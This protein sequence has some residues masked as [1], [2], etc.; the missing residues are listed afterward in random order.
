[1]TFTEFLQAIGL[2]PRNEKS[3]EKSP[4]KSFKKHLSPEQ[5]LLV[6]EEY[7]KFQGIVEK[8]FETS[9]KWQHDYIKRSNEVCPKCQSKNVNDRIQRL[10][11]EFSG[12]ISG[13]SSLLGGG[14]LSGHSSGKID[15]NEI[16]KCNDCQ[17]EWK[18]QKY[19]YTSVSDKAKS[20]FSDLRWLMNDYK[21]ALKVK[22]DPTDLAEKFDSDEQKQ[23]AEL[24]KVLTSYRFNEVKKFF[25]DYTIEGIYEIAKTVYKTSYTEFELNYFKEC[26]NPAF[27]ETY[28]E[29]KHIA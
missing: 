7:K 9:N 14:Y 4:E 8:E 12:S 29:F 24:K 13:S 10:Q 2:L 11:G 6:K 25:G 22:I 5:F 3:T 18:K 20:H 27:L 16:N 28:L 1:M 23:E 21:T 26:W 17:H 15:T 19:S